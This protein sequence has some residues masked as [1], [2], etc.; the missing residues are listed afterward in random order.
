MPE[1]RCPSL[2]NSVSNVGLSSEAV[3]VGRFSG[4]QN[5]GSSIVTSAPVPTSQSQLTV[6]AWV[7]PLMN[8]GGSGIVG[9][10]ASPGNWELKESSNAWDFAVYGSTDNNFGTVNPGTWEFITAVY[11]TAGGKVSLYVNGTPVATPRF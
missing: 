8:V 3:N 4:S 2:N 6:S 1:L 10:S 11:D 9:Q 5:S 7:Y